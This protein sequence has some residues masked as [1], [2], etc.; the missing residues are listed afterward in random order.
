MS[1]E[2]SIY[3]LLKAKFLIEDDAL[4]T[5]KFILFFVYSSYVDDCV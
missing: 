4:K 2:N 5:W 1:G 3:S